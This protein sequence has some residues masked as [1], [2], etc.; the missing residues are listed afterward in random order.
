M[1]KGD[2]GQ[3]LGDPLTPFTSSKSQAPFLWAGALISAAVG[4]AFLAQ[5]GLP[6]TLLPGL[7]LYA[8]ALWLFYR[9]LSSFSPSQDSKPLSSR[10]EWTLFLFILILAFG[11]RIYR[12]DSIP[13]GMHTDQGL[14]G[15]CALRIL[16][17]GWRPFGEV[18]DYEVPEVALFYQMAGWFALVGSSYFTFHLFF[19]LLALVAFPLI[20]WTVRQ[21][22]GQRTAL[23]S[24]FI[25]AAMRWNWIEPRNGYPSIQIPF[26]LF[27]ALAFWFYGHRK[28]KRWAIYL[29]ALFVGA[30]FYTY[31]AFKIVPLLMVVFA[32][33]EYFHQ[34]KKSLKPYV[35]YFLLILVLI[36]P[37]LAVMAQRGNIGHREA[38]LFIGSKVMQEGSLKP[39]WDVW[40]GTALM[41]NR[42]GDTNPRHNIPG[43]RMLDD[44]TAVFFILGLAL[45]WR[46]RKEPGFFY[47]LVG[48]GMMSLTGLLSTDPAHSN[49]LVSLTPF[50]AFFAG[51]AM[52]FFHQAAQHYLKRPGFITL[53]FDWDRVKSTLRWSV[54]LGALEVFLLAAMA[55]QNA[56]TYFVEQANNEECQNAFGLEQNHIGRTIEKR[57]QASPFS[58]HY[59]IDPSYFGNHTV[60]FLAYP[61]SQDVLAINPQHWAE[62]KIPKDK[63]ATV[64][65][66]KEKSGW[67]N[68]IYYD[69]FKRNLPTQPD[70]QKFVIY[71]ATISKKSLEQMKPWKR[72]LRGT[73]I[74]A[75]NWNSPPVIIRQDLVLNFTSK[76]DFPFTNFP[77][78]RIHWTGSLDVPKAGDYRFQVLTTD[79]GQLWLDG[80]PVLLEK[81]LKLTAKAHAL[82][83]DFE[84]EGGDAMALHLVWKKPGE[85]NWEIV[86]ATAFGVIH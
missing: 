54:A 51:S 75:A 76:Y 39:L 73:Y 53:L 1:I 69:A 62:G 63:E 3:T 85:P 12:I 31:Q 41:F 47:P 60:Q 11:F 22:A 55:A 48:F 36:A 64:L 27:G 84:K 68:F 33:D 5:S 52:N 79:N 24:L 14:I 19:T 46:R 43:H 77:P 20:Y 49:R 15:Q 38:G 42:M 78:F 9:S 30:G 71:E 80:K 72:G 7:A 56:Y 83:L 28:G 32:L 6:W 66:G 8:L 10:V 67:M 23:L 70:T 45:A 61:W 40:A 25:L 29:S 26:Y 82:Q 16:H 21:W 81:P 13:S 34:K 50:V 18:F 2:D 44:V 4:Q 65:L 37:L 74:N 17:E 86:P 58:N 57:E 35:L 59:F